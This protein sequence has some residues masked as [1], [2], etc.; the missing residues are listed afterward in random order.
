MN[1]WAMKGAGGW[2][3]MMIEN[4]Q[5]P[6]EE[7]WLERLVEDFCRVIEETLAV[8]KRVHI[9]LSGGTTPRSF[10]LSLNRATLP[11]DKIEWWLGDER[12]VKSTDASSNERMIK[13]TLFLNRADVLMHFK[14]WYLDQDPKKAASLYEERLCREI[15]NPPVFDLILL[16]L[17]NDG[18]IASLFPQTTVL[19]EKTHY[20][21]ANGVSSLNHVRLTLTF[22]TLNQAR[23]IWFLVRG[24]EK[25]PMVN[26]LLIQSEDIPAGHIKAACQKLYWCISNE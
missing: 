3:L 19:T 17:G 20:A 11:W 18:H 10:Y 12:W 23:S 15:G 22:P 4:F 16:G 8:R 9:A 24:N 21:L 5:F 13:E 2:L 1:Y 6:D 7:A 14:S 25:K 26:K